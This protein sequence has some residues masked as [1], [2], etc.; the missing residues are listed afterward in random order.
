MP[1]VGGKDK[2]TKNSATKSRRSEGI[3]ESAIGGAKIVDIH[4]DED[5]AAPN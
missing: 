5:I 3:H 4:R 2:P 1:V